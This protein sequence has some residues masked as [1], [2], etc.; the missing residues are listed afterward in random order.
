MVSEVCLHPI[1]VPYGQQVF[2]AGTVEPLEPSA[3]SWEQGS[4][5]GNRE[6]AIRVG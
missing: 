5:V 1:L 6:G 2:M 4:E 3:L